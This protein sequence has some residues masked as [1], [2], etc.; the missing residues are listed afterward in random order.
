MASADVTEVKGVTAEK[1]TDIEEIIQD[2]RMRD[3][4]YTSPFSSLRCMI[5]S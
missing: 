1:S 4:N 5:E 2:E 3:D